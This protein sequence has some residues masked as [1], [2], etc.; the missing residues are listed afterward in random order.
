MIIISVLY[1]GKVVTTDMHKKFMKLASLIAIILLSSAIAGQNM[2]AYA[3]YSNPPS[4][5]S[6]KLLKYADGLAINGNTIDI[7]KFSQKIPI[8]Q[9]LPIGKSSTIT[10]KIFDNEGPATIKSVSLYMNMQGKDLSNIGDTSISYPMNHH[11][12]LVD[13]H[14]LLGNVIAEYKIEQ[15][16]VY[17]TFHIPPTGKMDLSNL[18]V[19]AMDDHRSATSSLIIN[20]IQFS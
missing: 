15:P 19:S 10:L 1:Y 8:P 20:A 12:Y 11:L 14:N 5:G 6:G 3:A 18:V 7:S 13:P 9:I 4:F 16:F 2:S 17:V